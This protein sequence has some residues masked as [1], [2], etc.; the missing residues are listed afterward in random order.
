MLKGVE[1]EADRLGRF[2]TDEVLAE[3]DKMIEAAEN[4]AERKTA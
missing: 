1:E 4:E 2:E 3:I